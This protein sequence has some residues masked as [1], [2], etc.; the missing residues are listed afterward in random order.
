MLCVFVDNNS[1]DYKTQWSL[2]LFINSCYLS[3]KDG[4]MD[5]ADILSKHWEFP[6]IWPLLKPL[7]FWSGETAE[8]KQQPKQ[9]DTNATDYPFNE[10]RQNQN[11]SRLVTASSHC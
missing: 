9:T 3:G 1:C 7:L 8:I 5:P 2:T 11:D 6:Q 4:K 10:P